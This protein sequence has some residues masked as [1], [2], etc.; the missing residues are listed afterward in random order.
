MG[1]DQLSA[2]KKAMIQNATFDIVVLTTFDEAQKLSF[3]YFLDEFKHRSEANSLKY[4]NVE[5]FVFVDVDFG[6]KLGS[7]GSVLFAL[8]YLE[9]K[10]GGNFL[11]KQ[12]RILLIPVSG[13]SQR[14]V[15][16]TILG[17]IFNL[18]PLAA[19]R[20]TTF[21]DIKMMSY[22]KLIPF[23]PPG[24]LIAASDILEF[25]EDLPNFEGTS[26]K[27]ICLSNRKIPDSIFKK[28]GFTVLAFKSDLK[29]AFNH[30]CY[31]FERKPEHDSAKFVEI[32]DDIRLVLQKP[33]AEELIKNHACFVD[34]ET[35]EKYTYIDGVLFVGFDAIETLINFIR[36]EKFRI[37]SEICTF[38]DFLRPL[39]AQNSIAYAKCSTQ[40][41]L[42]HLLRPFSIRGLIFRNSV[43]YHMGTFPELL[44]HYCSPLESS[45]MKNF[46]GGIKPISNCIFL[47]KKC[48]TVTQD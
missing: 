38:G 17:K 47:P 12:K 44:R 28:D 46:G 24:V 36:S 37:D 19:D 18:A 33:T 13:M 1:L 14:Q 8:H 39:G 26:S 25:Y 9:E 4:K 16:G 21:F 48:D 20:E 27:D 45:F 43:F 23:M 42:Y 2:T 40:K 35:A 5:F 41:K 15:N 7:G 31:I 3:E 30:G 34:Q 11:L 22:E 32:H 10:F 6:V 29:T